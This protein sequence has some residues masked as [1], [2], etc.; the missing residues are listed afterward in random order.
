MVAF[1]YLCIH[2]VCLSRSWLTRAFSVAP[3]RWLG[4]MTYSYYLIHGLALKAVVMLLMLQAPGL[5]MN[6]PVAPIAL[7]LVFG[8]TLLPTAALFLF[9]ER[10]FSLSK[11]ASPTAPPVLAPI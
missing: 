6:A 9:I 8:L 11:R 7:P 4:N 10:P 1:F 3:L 5:Q 2:C